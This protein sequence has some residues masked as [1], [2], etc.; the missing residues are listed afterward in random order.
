[1]FKALLST[2][3]INDLLHGKDWHECALWLPGMM[4]FL[5]SIYSGSKGLARLPIPVFFVMQNIVLVFKATAE[6]VFHRQRTSLYSYLMLMFSLISAIAVAK[7]DPQFEPEGYF[8]MSVHIISI[9][10]FEIYTNML[11]GRLK[12]KAT[13]RLFCCYFY[14]VIVLTPC[15]YFLGDALEAVKF[16]YLYF[17]QFYVGC[18]LS[19]VLGMLMNLSAIRLHELN[20]VNSLLDIGTIQIFAKMLCSVVSL[21]F[22]EIEFSNSFAFLLVINFLCS[23]GFCESSSSRW[24]QDTGSGTYYQDM[25]SLPSDTDIINIRQESVKE[26]THALRKHDMQ[27]EMIR[28]QHV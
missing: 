24:H 9:G 27:Q 1:M 16:P 28:L 2:G 13:E 3:H 11:K 12:L 25:L 14:S 23:F 22:F 5:I 20:A 17:A 19:G 4:C 18:I 15:S 26:T 6:L 21:A 8:W 10:V 7:T